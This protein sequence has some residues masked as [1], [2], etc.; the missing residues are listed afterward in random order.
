VVPVFSQVNPLCFLRSCPSSISQSTV[1]VATG[2]LFG[3]LTDCGTG[4]PAF[5]SVGSLSPVFLQTVK[6]HD[7]LRHLSFCFV[8]FRIIP[9]ACN[10]GRTVTWYRLSSV[11]FII[12]AKCRLCFSIHYWN[13][14]NIC[15][16]HF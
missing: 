6:C 13:D 12:L 7:M 3:K 8:C 2:I 16:A 1:R 4:V 5:G 15:S 11:V 10:V 14:H 9:E